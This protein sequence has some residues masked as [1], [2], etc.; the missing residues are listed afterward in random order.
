M[1]T[2]VV[3][4]ALT[5]ACRLLTPALHIWNFVPVGAVALYAGSRLPRRWAWA[6]PVAALVLS[7]IVLD[8]G[9]HRPVFELTRWTIYATFAA[10]TWLGLV[11]NGPRFRP[12]ML[13]GLSL[14]ASSVFFAT[15]NLAVWA[16]DSFIPRP[17]R[18]WSHVITWR[19]PSSVI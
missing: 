16:E 8:S 15:S 5:V 2:G 19:S 4:V 1:V 17:L 3:L 18:A 7:D 11:A 13:P 14:L 10:M 6:V 12:W 9:Q